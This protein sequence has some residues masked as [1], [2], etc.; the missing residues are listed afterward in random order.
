MRRLKQLQ[1]DAVYHLRRTA[2]A[3]HEQVTPL[4]ERAQDE[5]RKLAETAIKEAKKATKFPL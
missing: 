1:Q 4:V 5:S 3:T 2:D